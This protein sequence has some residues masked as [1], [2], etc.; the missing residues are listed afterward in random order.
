VESPAN[1]VTVKLAEADPAGTVTDA[2]I[3]VASLLADRPTTAPPADAG[4]DSATVQTVGFPPVTI[5]GEHCID[6]SVIDGI[7]TD[8]DVVC[9]TPP[10]LAVIAAD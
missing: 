3:V 7:V 5:E 2:G 9:D 4:L 8:N 1:V 6:S 10:K